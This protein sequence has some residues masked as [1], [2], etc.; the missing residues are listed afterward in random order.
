[1]SRLLFAA[2]PAFAATLFA[3][4]ES[5]STPGDINGSPRASAGRGGGFSDVARPIFL[6]GRV[7]LED[8]TAP[9][10]RVA[11]ERV[12]LG[13]PIIEGYTDSKGRFSFELGRRNGVGL[14]AST[15]DMAD[16]SSTIG[17][18]SS[19]G[20][21]TMANGTQAGTLTERDLLSCEIRAI[22]AGYYA[23]TVQ[24]AGRRLLDKPDLGTIVLRQVAGVNGYTFSATTSLA[25]KDAKKNYDKGVEELNKKRYAEAAKE[26]EK[27][28]A[29]F[30]KFASAWSALGSARAAQGNM[31]GALE[32]YGKAA[33]ADD[34][35]LTPHM[36]MMQIYSKLSRWE[37]IARESSRV[38]QLNSVQYPVAYYLNAAANFN[39]KAYEPAEKSAR[40]TIK[41]DT[42]HRLPRAELLLG[43]LLARKNE[44][45]EAVQVLRSYAGRVQGAD[46]EAAQK[47]LAEVES[48]LK[49]N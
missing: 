34:R 45:A 37:D 1:M 43:M 17:G 30:P 6:S 23:P 28:V 47:Q 29:A 31:D 9:P 41:L 26:L 11:L 22:L 8:G 48:R 38:I 42:D 36:E 21:S 20:R 10:D 7:M 40:E 3:Q 25:P 33:E 24:L 49:A 13:S 14:D 18:P 39:L 27:A 46:L 12:C 44:N 19:T 4:A 2:V 5:P 15:G 32:A 35:Y 16:T